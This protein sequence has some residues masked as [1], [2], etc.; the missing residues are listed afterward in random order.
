MQHAEVE[1]LLF[2]E[3]GYTGDERLLERPVISPFGKGSVDIGVMNF[4]LAIGTFR[5]GHARPLHPR[6]Q[7]PQN[8]VE[9]AMI[10]QF[11]LRPALG[12]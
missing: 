7:H 4:R 12:H 1:F 11:A 2:G 8:E 9:E 3:M 10:A 5:N 6:I